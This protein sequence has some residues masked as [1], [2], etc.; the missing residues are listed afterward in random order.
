MYSE[1]VA[2]AQGKTEEPELPRQKKKPRRFVEDRDLPA[3]QFHTP[4]AFHRQEFLTA[5][6]LSEKEV[7]RRAEQTSFTVVS[8]L[9][10]ISCFTLQGVTAR[11]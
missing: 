1:T 6:E 4:K 9:W 7:E 8:A 11:R 2:Q 3:A 10:K 5:V